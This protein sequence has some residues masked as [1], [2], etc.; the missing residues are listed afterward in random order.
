MNVGEWLVREVAKL[1]PK[2]MDSADLN[3]D[4]TWEDT[5]FDG[6]DA[7]DILEAVKE[8]YDIGISQDKFCDFKT[9][10]DMN[11]YIMEQLNEKENS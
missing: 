7:D 3:L 4:Y 10:A 1:M 11:K 5:G 8:E 6:C 2:H 9:L